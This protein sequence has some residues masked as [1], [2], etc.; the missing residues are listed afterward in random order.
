MGFSLQRGIF[1]RVS[2]KI[3]LDRAAKTG[4][5]NVLIDP[6]SVRSGDAALDNV[7]KGEAYFNVERFPTLTFRSS[8]VRF[9]GERVV[10][11]VGDFTMLGVTRPVTLKVDDFVCGNDPFFRR[12]LCG[13]EVTTTIKRSDWGMTRGIP[14]APADEVKISIPVEAYRE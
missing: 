11:V 10:E 8:N 13:A 6:T 14:L 4:T 12:P 3:T 1:T 5:V 9:D 2:G 7:L